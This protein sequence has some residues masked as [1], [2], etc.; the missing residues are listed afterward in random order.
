MTIAKAHWLLVSGKW[1]EVKETMPVI[2]KYNGETI[3]TVP[4]GSRETV[5]KA[6]ASEAIPGYARLLV[7]RR[8]LISQKTSQLLAKHQDENAQSSAGRRG[9]GRGWI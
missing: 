3:G 6:I 7:H 4:V 9:D 1:I 5:K 8:F 2:D